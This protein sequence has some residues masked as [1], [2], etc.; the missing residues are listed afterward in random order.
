MFSIHPIEM[1]WI[2]APS[3]IKVNLSLSLIIEILEVAE[4]HRMEVTFDDG[5]YEIILNKLG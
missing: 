5:K 3:D 2:Q 4:N 1:M